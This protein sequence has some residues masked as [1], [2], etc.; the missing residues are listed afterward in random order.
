VF[1]CIRNMSIIPPTPA[2]FNIAIV[3]DDP[4]YAHAI[5]KRI[6]KVCGY[7]V[8]PIF[9]NGNDFLSYAQLHQID[10]VII[11]F[12]LPIL[13]GYEI[14]VEFRKTKPDTPVIFITAFNFQEYI[15]DIANIAY[16][17]TVLKNN[18]QALCEIID[19]MIMYKCSEVPDSVLRADEIKLLHSIYHKKNTK[20]IASLFNISEE[21]IK[22]R[23]RN[24]AIK[25]GIENNTTAFI[26]WTFNNY[27]F[28]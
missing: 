24:L 9:N 22:K 3:D 5:K 17:A 8:P 27:P 25:L 19:N 1:L 21:A 14:I 16:S 13:T 6:E 20:Q 2:N 11:D 15:Q 28:S 4:Q 23:K 12:E 10:L 7:D 26:K 18:A